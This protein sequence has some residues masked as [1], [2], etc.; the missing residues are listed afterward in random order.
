MASNS[1][2]NQINIPAAVL[3]V[4]TETTSYHHEPPPPYYSA[5]TAV[6]ERPIIHQTIIIQASLRDK[7]ML[8]ECSACR[9]TVFTKVRYVNS[10]K[11][12]LI[13]GFICGFTVWCMLCCLAAIPYFVPAFKKAEHYCPICNQFLGSYTKI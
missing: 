7:P 12:H 1:D 5:G 6:T 8:Y 3:R 13:A 2:E 11:T 10:Q 4:E 9:E